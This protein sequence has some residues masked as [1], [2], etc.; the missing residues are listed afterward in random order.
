MIFYEIL[1][2]FSNALLADLLFQCYNSIILYKGAIV[3]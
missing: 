3:L 2:H 1:L